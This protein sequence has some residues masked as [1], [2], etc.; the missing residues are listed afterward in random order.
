MAARRAICLAQLGRLEEA[1][2]LI[3]PLLH[4]LVS[5][6]D[7]EVVITELVWVLQAAVVVEHRAAAQALAARLA[8]LASVTEVGHQ[9]VTTCVGRHLGDAA[10]MAGDRTAAGAYYKQALE[11]AGRI[12][13]RPELALTHL[14]LAELLLVDSDDQAQAEALEHLD[15]A[16]P[17]LRDMHMQPGLE[18]GLA[19]REKLTPATAREPAR[20]SA[21][22]TLTAREREIAR[23]VANRL[24]NRDI[25]EKLVISEG[26]V[27]VHVKHILGKLGFS[28][29]AQVAGW[30]ARQDPG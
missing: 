24:S 5:R 30:F 25:A 7:H 4:D 20:Q 18:R 15:V 1:R 21:S 8:C 26:T 19:L 17:E 22:D 9:G 29:R 12:R 13:F 16:I 11:T 10:A 23:L 27:E 28:S 2:T 6:S 14:R 3:G